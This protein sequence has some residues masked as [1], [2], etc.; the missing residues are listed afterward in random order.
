MY[1]LLITSQ[2]APLTTPDSVKR[3]PLSGIVMDSCLRKDFAPDVVLM[4]PEAEE[5]TVVDG[6]E[7]QPRDA[8]PTNVCVLMEACDEVASSSD[9]NDGPDSSLLLPLMNSPPPTLAEWIDYD[10]STVA[11]AEE[12][13]GSSA[14]AAAR[15]AASFPLSYRSSLDG[16]NCAFPPCFPSLSL[17]P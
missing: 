15:N 9:G 2:G 7:R 6:V 10:F 1:P 11:P 5:A 4:C 16:A 13:G 3:I 14:A 8:Q 12:H 17:L